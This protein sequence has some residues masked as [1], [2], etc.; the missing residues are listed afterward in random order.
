[1][2]PLS[3]FSFH[4]NCPPSPVCLF[5]YVCQSVRA[6][7]RVC[8]TYVCVCMLACGS[9]HCSRPRGGLALT[10]TSPQAPGLVGCLVLARHVSWLSAVRLKP[11]L[12]RLPGAGAILLSP[13]T[14][15]PLPS[16]T[17]L[18]ASLFLTEQAGE[19]AKKIKSTSTHTHT[20]PISCSFSIFTASHKLVWICAH[21][22]S[23]NCICI[24]ES[25]LQY[26]YCQ[27]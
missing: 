14:C 25:T 17:L 2:L 27:G 4:S 20:L 19:L 21:Q 23:T 13:Q 16:P 24:S 1:M 3:Y 26:H 5:A 7:T 15:S 11:T 18:E 6:C 8:D 22:A 12:G 10:R 9:W